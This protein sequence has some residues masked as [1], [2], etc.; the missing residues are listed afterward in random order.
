M[1]SVLNSIDFKAYYLGTP[2]SSSAVFSVDFMALC[3]TNGASESQRDSVP[4]PGVGRRPTPGICKKPDNPNGVA[5]A[6]PGAGYTPQRRTT[7]PRWGWGIFHLLTQG[8]PLR[9][10]PLWALGRNPFGIFL[11][12]KTLDLTLNTNYGAF[13]DSHNWAN[14]RETQRDF[15]VPEGHNVGRNRHHN[16]VA[17]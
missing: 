8:S 2:T 1:H 3:R 17:M 5:S 7:Q 11:I 12:L 13:R 4:K 16:P 15:G 14:F 9:A 10:Q 6:L